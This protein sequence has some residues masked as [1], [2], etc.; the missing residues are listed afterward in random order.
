MK[1]KALSSFAEKDLEAKCSLAASSLFLTSALLTLRA[2]KKKVRLVRR[3]TFIAA[4]SETNIRIMFF[5]IC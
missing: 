2:L 1:K 3:N 5:P 4:F